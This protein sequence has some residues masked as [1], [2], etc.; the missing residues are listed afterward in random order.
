MLFTFGNI[1]HQPHAGTPPANFGG[2]PEPLWS[3]L[4]GSPG[5]MCLLE[6]QQLFKAS[7]YSPF[8]D[9]TIIMKDGKL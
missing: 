6:E 8:S 4:G 7:V 9:V 1:C 2:W 3:H 5:L